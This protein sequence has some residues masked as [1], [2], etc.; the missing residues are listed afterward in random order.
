MTIESNGRVIIYDNLVK[1]YRSSSGYCLEELNNIMKDL[2]VLVHQNIII[3][4]PVCL[5]GFRFC[6]KRGYYLKKSLLHRI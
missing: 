6:V 2:K 5:L 4:L 1:E 3:M